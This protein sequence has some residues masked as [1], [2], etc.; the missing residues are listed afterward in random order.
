MKKVLITGANSYIGTSFEKYVNTNYKSEIEIDTLDMMNPHWIEQDFS[1]YDCIF[2]VAGIAHQKETK[3][4]KSSYSTYIHNFI[5]I[6]MVFHFCRTLYD[7]FLL[8]I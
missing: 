3:E 8:H 5:S 6:Y 1:K 4:N 2:H 7:T